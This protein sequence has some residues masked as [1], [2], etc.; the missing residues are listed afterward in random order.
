MFEKFKKLTKEVAGKLEKVDTQEAEQIQQQA[1]TVAQKAR[2]LQEQA[3]QGK[4]E[5]KK[6][7]ETK[8]ESKKFLGIFKR[9]TK[10]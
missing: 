9:A 3:K 7:I 4:P 5:L 6:V 1:L 2:L 10:E 8:E